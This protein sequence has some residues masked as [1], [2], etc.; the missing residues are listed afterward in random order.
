MGRSGAEYLAGFAKSAL[1]RLDESFCLF[2]WGHPDN[3]PREVHTPLYA[4]VVVLQ[5]VASKRKLAFVVCDLLVISESVRESVVRRLAEIGLG[6]EEYEIALT[7]THTHSGPSGYSTY[8]LYALNA[9]GFSTEVHDAFVDAIVDAIFRANLRAEPARLFVGSGGI[10]LSDGIAFNRSIEA[11]NRNLDVTPLPHD[12]R[13]EAVDR[14]MTVLTVDGMSGQP[15]GMV[16]WLGIHGTCVHRDHCAIHPDHKGEAA[17]LAEE[18]A[19]GEGATDFVALFAQG[20]AGD[21]TPNHRFDERRG[22]LV[23]KYDDD[24]AS[25]TFV[26]AVQARHA[27]EIA[28]RARAERSEVRE[29]LDCRLEFVDFF[30]APVH[31]DFALGRDDVRTSAPLMGLGFAFGTEEGPGPLASLSKSAAVHAPIADV[32]RRLGAASDVSGRSQWPK[33]PFWDLH[34]GRESRI[35][36]VVPA[37]TRLARYAPSRFVTYFH[38]AVTESGAGELPWV[39]RFLPAHLVR[40]G[41]LALALLP[42][43][44]TVTTGK[45]IAAAV[46]RGAERSIAHVVVNGYAN[47]YAGYAATPEEYDL[48]RYEGSSTFFGPLTAPAWCTAFRRLASTT[49]S[50]RQ[51]RP[52]TRP[53]VRPLDSW[54]PERA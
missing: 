46:R 23:G 33:L 35:A 13:D 10:P 45:R 15:L 34:R 20:A 53:P 36:G 42:M 1:D 51:D 19:A 41:P 47:A 25:A 54:V 38:K 21:V 3:V 8:L 39:P 7:A 14:T 12:R 6:F 49:D 18:A 26:G 28:E 32:L 29:A 5:H 22:M 37:S 43:E 30:Q 44:P 4:R 52:D 11:F 2:G 50:V 9:P 17:R 48:Q 24:F 27:W 16:S 31:P 40:L